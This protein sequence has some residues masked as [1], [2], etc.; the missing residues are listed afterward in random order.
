LIFSNWN[1]DEFN[2]FKDGKSL[3]S[4]PLKPNYTNNMYLD[5]Y[6]AM[7]NFVN[8]MSEPYASQLEY[9]SFR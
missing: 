7:L 8:G 3:L 9:R 5:C 2:A 6:W 1:V 4:Q